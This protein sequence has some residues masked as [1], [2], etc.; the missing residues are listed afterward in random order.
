MFKQH[1]DRPPIIT[2]SGTSKIGKST[3]ANKFG[4]KTAN[5][6]TEDIGDGVRGDKTPLAKSF[7]EVL[8]ALGHLATA[9]HDYDVTVTDSLDWLGMLINKQICQENGV[10]TIEKIGYGKGYIMGVD[11]WMQYIDC[12]KYLRDHRNMTIINIAH[13]EI[14]KFE[15]PETEAY[16]RYQLKLHKNAADLIMESS[17]M[18]LFINYYVGITKATEAGGF[19]KDRIRAIGC[20]ERVLYTEERP[21]FKAGNRFGLPSEIPFDIEGKYWDIIKSHIPYYNQKTGA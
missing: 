3:G 15:N 7:K 4:K 14:K 16:D 10:P 9:K 1:E 8:E 6:Q 12:I 21:A 5:I 20:G 17:D 11:L 19:K 13:T 2:L 18:I